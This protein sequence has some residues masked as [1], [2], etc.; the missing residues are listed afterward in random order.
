M[1]CLDPMN[2]LPPPH[3]PPHSSPPVLPSKGT[4]EPGL[5]EFWSTLIESFAATRGTLAVSASDV[6]AHFVRGGGARSFALRPV[7]NHL[8]RTQAL[9]PEAELA[10][11]AQR[12]AVGKAVGLVS[13]PVRWA[14]GYARG[15]SLDTPLPE[16]ALVVQPNLGRAAAAFLRY[17]ASLPRL[18]QT[19]FLDAPAT[20]P[21]SASAASAEGAPAQQHMPSPT[22]VLGVCRR[23]AAASSA[24][25]SGAAE[26]DAAMAAKR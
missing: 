2:T 22:T 20:P 11:L 4:L 16:G 25:S 1:G 18:E 14:W 6:E 17:C 21:P 24:G 26:D 3:S 13:A 8:L 10:R 15:A 12:G 7:V 19:L 5:L 9:Q 23:A